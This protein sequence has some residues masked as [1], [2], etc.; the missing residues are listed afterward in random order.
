MCG[1]FGYTLSNESQIPAEELHFAVGVL[2]ALNQNRGEHSWGCWNGKE[3]HKFLGGVSKAPLNMFL[4]S[5]KMFGHTRFATVGARTQR[6]AHPFRIKG[7]KG[8]IIGA[9]NGSV[10]NYDDLAK[11]YEWKELEVDSEAIFLAIA[12]GIDFEEVRGYGAIEYV[13]E[14]DPSRI[15]LCRLNGQLSI[16]RVKNKGRVEGV[17]WSSDIDHLKKALAVFDQDDKERWSIE[18]VTIEDEKAYEVRLDEED[19]TANVFKTDIVHKLGGRYSST[20]SHSTGYAYDT[21]PTT[22]IRP[23]KISVEVLKDDVKKLGAMISKYWPTTTGAT[24][25]PTVDTTKS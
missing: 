1:I 21:K 3:L 24:T 17:F 23:E 9:H 2:K 13:W 20:S 19:G 25:T 8:T 4:Q 18:M 14:N 6:N 16:A 12:N 7:K 22:S 10:S 15:Y 11:K 5:N